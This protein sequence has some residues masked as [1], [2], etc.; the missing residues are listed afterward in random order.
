MKTI[1]DQTL[2]E[3]VSW[4]LAAERDDM[5]WDAFTRWL[6]ANP[7][8]RTAYDEVA[9]ADDL[10]LRH[11]P[12]MARDFA[13]PELRPA[14]PATRSRWP[15]WA[16]GALAASLVALMV[17]PQVTAPEPVTYTTEG[18]SRTVALADGSQVI[19]AP[20]SRLVVSGREQND[21]ALEGGAF[22]DIRHDPGRS[23][24]VHAG[25]L[26]VTDIGT[27]FDV[28]TGPEGARVKVAQ[29]TV[30]VESEALA[31]PIELT[32]GKALTYDPARRRAIVAKV[33]VEDVG[34]WRKGR[35]TF[36]SAP[37]ALVAGD[38]ARYAHV[39]VQVSPAV[40]DRRFSGT[41]SIGDGKTAVRDLAQ[42]MELALVRDGTAYRLEPAR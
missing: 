24:V 31:S 22:F 7:L 10:A 14:A 23:L 12:A 15:L 16:G 29:G 2:D 20:Q 40:K 38:L 34:G 11:G 35:L 32:A 18:Q 39:D 27:M 41:L 33:S 36:T 8:H 42:L 17:V 26:D 21:L 30:S 1:P 25:A 3:A 5:D 6:E 4:H 13:E 9:L 28:Q 19:V 37:L